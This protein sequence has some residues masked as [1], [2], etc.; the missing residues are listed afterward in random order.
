LRARIHTQEFTAGGQWALVE[1]FLVI[2]CT[3]EPT[4]FSSSSIGNGSGAFQLD[5]ALCRTARDH[6]EWTQA[7]PPDDLRV[8]FGVQTMLL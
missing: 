5:V 2:P 6:T 8:E 7:P 3:L 1:Q 4:S